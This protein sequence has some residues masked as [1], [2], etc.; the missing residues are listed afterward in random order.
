MATHWSVRNW[1]TEIGEI[2]FQDGKWALIKDSWLGMP[3]KI[4]LVLKHRCVVYDQH[5]W[6]RLN[7][8]TCRA[9]GDTAPDEIVGLQALANWDR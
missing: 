3:E 7:T 6:W 9:C 4:E 1:N 5:T 8:T 2:A